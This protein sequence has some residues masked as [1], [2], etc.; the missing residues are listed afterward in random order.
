MVGSRGGVRNES[1]VF[2]PD[3]LHC[4]VM[5]KTTDG[6][7]LGKEFERIYRLGVESEESPI[8]KRGLL[9]FPSIQ[10]DV[11]LPD[12]ATDQDTAVVGP[13]DPGLEL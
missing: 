4:T 11:P 5:E 3:V 8:P 7:Y 10:P 9:E 6:E 13:N 1:E 2:I 12:P